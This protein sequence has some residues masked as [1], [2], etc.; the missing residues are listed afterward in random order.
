MTVSNWL[1]WTLAGAIVIAGRSFDLDSPAA[2]TIGSR[3]SQARPTSPPPQGRLRKLNDGDTLVLDNEE[4]IK[5]IQR[6]SAHVRAVFNAAERWLILVLDFP[7]QSGG[8]PD[9]R[10]DWTYSFRDLTGNWPFGERWEGGAIVED[11]S[12]AG[13]PGSQGV[14]LRTHQGLVQFMSPQLELFR[15][16]AAIAQLSHTGAGRSSTGSVSFDEAELRALSD[17]K[18]NVAR[19]AQFPEGPRS[20]V[21]SFGPGGTGIAT[22]TGGFSV[23]DGIPPAR[24]GP[25][26]VGGNVRSPQ[27]IHDVVPIL[28]ERARQ[29]GIRGV[30]ILELTIG[31][32]GSVT[33]VRVLRSF[34]LLDEAAVAAA[35][36]WR[37]EP[38]MLNGTPV[39]VTMTATVQFKDEQ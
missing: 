38:V 18:R 14:G 7:P 35:R 16:P 1:R 30:V 29:A 4:R 32:D 34:P 17:M 2:Q 6:R 37:Y 13:Q 24:G 19:D 22:L 10:A 3:L 20:T 27:K 8:E 23:G 5:V 36:Q 21:T 31:A 25:M 26:R 15:D 39:P 28:P 11:Y 9:G 12:M 33:D